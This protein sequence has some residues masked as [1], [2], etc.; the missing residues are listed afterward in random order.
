MEKKGKQE[1]LEKAARLRQIRLSKGMTQEAFAEMLGVSVKAYKAVET[2]E[3]N[4]SLDMLSR[5]KNNASV[6]SDYILYG[7]AKDFDETWIEV[8]SCD[9]KSKMQIL[10]RLINYF[11]NEKLPEISTKDFTLDKIL[12][13]NENK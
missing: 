12:R 5:I 9:D 7:N 1:R 2:G 13:E 6:S 4:L 11:C 8:N 3:N 10:I